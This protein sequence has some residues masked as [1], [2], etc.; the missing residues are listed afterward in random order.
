[1]MRPES[2][3]TSPLDGRAADR[4]REAACWHLLGRLFEC[5]SPT[6]RE[7]I[8]RL[9]NEIRDADLAAAVAAADVATEGLYHSVFGPGG[10][11]PPREASYRETIELGS[12]MSELVSCYDAFGYRPSI[13][14]APDHIAVETG[15]VAYLLFK[16][17][18]ALASGDAEHA[19]MTARAATRF[20]ADHLAL[21]AAPLAALLA[22]SGIGYLAAASRLLSLR[23]GEPPARPKLIVVQDPENDNADICCGGQPPV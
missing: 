23:A 16:E 8:L 11:A 12:L 13:G 6:W 20:C 2:Y 3:E 1:M 22:D 5:P 21:A 4:L 14:E 17:A 10:P 7:D 18:Y 9:A 15:F 19:E